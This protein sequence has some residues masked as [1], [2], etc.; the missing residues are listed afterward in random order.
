MRRAGRPP[1][2]RCGAAAASPPHWFRGPVSALV[3]R[4]GSPGL[5][6]AA[7]L[8]PKI[9]LGAVLDA[10]GYPMRVA[11]GS[12]APGPRARL[13]GIAVSCP[14][15]L[16][17]LPFGFS[18][19]S[20]ARSG[21]FRRNSHARKSTSATPAPLSQWTPA[22]KAMTGEMP[23]KMAVDGEL[24]DKLPQFVLLL[25]QIL[26]RAK[27]GRQC[28]ELTPICRSQVTEDPRP[29]PRTC[30]GRAAKAR[31]VYTTSISSASSNDRVPPMR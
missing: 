16:L 11:R 3:L 8:H 27:C 10:Q 23:A 25:V 12:R 31:T 13:L 6:L 1:R 4:H 19:W 28:C 17:G 9:H 7:V 29:P 30:F 24:G 2:R 18:C 15:K 5:L 21:G 14:A 26:Q 20:T 22:T